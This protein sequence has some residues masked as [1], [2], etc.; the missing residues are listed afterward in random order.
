MRFRPAVAYIGLVSATGAA[1]PGYSLLHW[2]T[3]DWAR[4]LFDGAIA[5]VASRMKVSS[6]CEIIVENRGW[7]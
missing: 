3:R 6:R 1:S 7:G 5:L 4:Y 2:Q